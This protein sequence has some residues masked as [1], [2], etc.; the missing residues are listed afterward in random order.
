MTSQRITVNAGSTVLGGR[1]YPATNGRPKALL[2]AIHG[3]V[4]TSKYFD[5]APQNLLEFGASLGYNMLALD[6]PGYGASASLP[7][8]VQTLDGQIPLVRQAIETAWSSYGQGT[9][10]IVL[11]GHSL[12]GMVS[13]LLAAQQPHEQLLGVHVTG[14]GPVSNEAV[15][16]AIS[17]TPPTNESPRMEGPNPFMGPVWT[18]PEGVSLEAPELTAPFPLPDF[19]GSMNWAE[20]LPQVAAQVRVPVRFVV[21]EFDIL[22][23]SDPVSLGRVPAMFKAAPFVDVGVQRQAGHLLDLSTIARAQFMKI[24]AFAEECINARFKQEAA[25]WLLQ[26]EFETR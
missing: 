20:R 8:E 4:V 26:P 1:F 15:Q 22:W 2:I 9:A 12:G 25:R 21:P 24:L 16:A 7:T 23:K 11:V 5:V 3:A 13:L 17:T 14:S 18:Y 6:R 19:A 10:G